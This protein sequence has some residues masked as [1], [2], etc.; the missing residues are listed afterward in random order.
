MN[1][2]AVQQSSGLAAAAVPS[3]HAAIVDQP[4]DPHGGELVDDLLVE[5]AEVEVRAYPGVV[6]AGLGAT[7]W[8]HPGVVVDAEDGAVVYLAPRA[9]LEEWRPGALERGSVQII[10]WEPP[11]YGPTADNVN[12]VNTVSTSGCGAVRRCAVCGCTD[13]RACPGSCWWVAAD[14]CSTCLAGVDTAHSH[15]PLTA[16]ETTG[17]RDEPRGH[18][19]V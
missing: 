2:G 15:R 11:D 14:L 10:P 9:Y 4:E 6:R 18:R 19:R 8:A 17:A 7:V 5:D 3:C 13:E 1:V 12:N 16:P